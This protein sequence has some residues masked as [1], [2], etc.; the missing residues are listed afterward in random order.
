M[1]QNLTGWYILGGIGCF[2]LFAGLFWAVCLNIVWSSFTII[3]LI[4][5]AYVAICIPSG[6]EW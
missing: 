2:L 4:I 6:K 3:G 5:C 1:K